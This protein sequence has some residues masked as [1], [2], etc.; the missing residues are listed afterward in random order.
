VICQGRA[1][2]ENR[3]VTTVD[4]GEVLAFAREMGTKL[5]GKM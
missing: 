5:W 3:R 2:V 4:E 1:I